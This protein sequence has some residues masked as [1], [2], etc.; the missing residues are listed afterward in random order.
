MS[1]LPGKFVWFEHMSSDIP[2]A[3]AFY[4]AL[5]NWNTEAMKMGGQTYYM[6]HNGHDGIGGYRSAT[7]GATSHW[8]SYLSVLDVDATFATAIRAGAK[9]QMP[10]T[11]FGD[12]G[13]GA[14]ITD[15]TGAAFS[16]WKSNSSDRIDVP[17]TPP[18]DWAWNELWTPDE[19]TALAFYEK[20]FGYTHDKMDMG[21][22]GTYH[23]LKMGGV[24]RAG[25]MRSAQPRAPAMWLPYVEVDDCDVSVGEASKLGAKVL[26]AATDIPGVGRFAIFA[27]PVGA[28][29]AVIRSAPGAG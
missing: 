6:I 25:L 7:P 5:F 14:S 17:R 19:R 27:D 24:P 23:V 20:V 22:Q 3:R 1:Y 8:A 4:D 12:V 9:S 11:N 15:P 28:A 16:I 13:R 10:P 29:F 21:P 18:G 26:T 2:K